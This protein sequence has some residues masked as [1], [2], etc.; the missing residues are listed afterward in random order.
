MLKRNFYKPFIVAI[1]VSLFLI[2]ITPPLMVFARTSDSS[3]VNLHSLNLSAMQKTCQILAIV[4][5][6]GTIHTE[7]RKQHTDGVA[8]NLLVRG[9]DCE[10]YYGYEKEFI[11]ANYSNTAYLCFFG[12]GSTS[13]M[14]VSIQEVNSI[15]NTA[16]A[17]GWFRWYPAAVFRVLAAG[18]QYWWGNGKTNTLITQL[19]A[20]STVGGQC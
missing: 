19:C 11:I 5:I 6:H 14:G 13:Y 8:P 18:D 10:Q 1:V 16:G 15:T 4:S 17:A 20:G 9:S 7:C 12:D 2:G 3:S